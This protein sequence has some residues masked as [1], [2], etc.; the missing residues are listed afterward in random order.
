MQFLSS[1]MVHTAM[2]R[3]TSPR[4]NS[5]C[6]GFLFPA[7]IAVLA[8][9][10]VVLACRWVSR[11]ER[12][13][14]GSYKVVYVYSPSCPHCVKFDPAWSQFADKVASDRPDVGVLKTTDSSTYK[15]DGFPTVIMMQGST[16][17]ATFSGDRSAKGLW[18]WMTGIAK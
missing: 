12:F 4:P 7:A 8:V 9:A 16:T 1:H 6:S 18:D 14:E 3:K 15:V 17:V 11:T 5:S 10:G 2:P 13:Q